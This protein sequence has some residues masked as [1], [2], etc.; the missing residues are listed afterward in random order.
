MKFINCFPITN[1]RR[2][3]L[4]F[5]SFK[6]QSYIQ[7]TVDKDAEIRVPLGNGLGI[8]FKW[9]EFPGFRDSN[10]YAQPRIENA[11]LRLEYVEIDQLIYVPYMHFN[12]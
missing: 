9:P 12:L 5:T 1:R 3:L 8:F 2:W 4:G 11:A 10:E 6:S 7:Y